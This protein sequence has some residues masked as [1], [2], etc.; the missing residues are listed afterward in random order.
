MGGNE[1]MCDDYHSSEYTFRGVVQSANQFLSMHI[2]T[3]KTSVH[4]SLW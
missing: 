2:L 3:R 1:N 4:I